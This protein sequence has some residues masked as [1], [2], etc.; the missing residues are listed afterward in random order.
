MSTE[1][2][3]PFEEFVALRD[4]YRK[5]MDT[6]RLVIKY[7]DTVEELTPLGL[8]KWY[9]YPSQRDAAMDTQLFYELTIPPGSRSGRWQAQGGSAAI[10]VEGFGHSVVNGKRHDWEAVNS[11]LLPILQEGVD[12]QHFNDSET[13]QVRM[14][15]ALPNLIH[16]MGVDMGAGFEVIEPSPEYELARQEDGK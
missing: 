5:R 9:L 10:V 12:V 16:A 14:V 8:L 15:V 6:A 2:V 11:I 3:R 13:E 7:E 4:D 1:T